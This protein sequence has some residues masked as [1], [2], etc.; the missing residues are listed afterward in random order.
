LT[1]IHGE[2]RMQFDHGVSRRDRV[3]TV[4]LNFVVV[5]REDGGDRCQDESQHSNFHGV[6]LIVDDYNRTKC[7]CEGTCCAKRV[8]NAL[9]MR[10][11][12]RRIP[13]GFLNG[14]PWSAQGGDE[15]Y[16]DDR[17]AAGAY[18]RLH[19]G[20]G[21]DISVQRLGRT[22]STTRNKNREL[23]QSTHSDY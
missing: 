16:A 6:S 9:D 7:A 13:N 8:S 19:G 21:F 11:L 15:R 14:S 18:H 12:E 17:R 1:A 4:D 23:H 22:D 10:V 2:I 20:C 5:L 3:G